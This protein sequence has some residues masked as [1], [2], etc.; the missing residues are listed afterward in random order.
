MR[1]RR[2]C[3]GLNATVPGVPDDRTATPTLADLGEDALLT[4]IFPRLPSTSGALVGP[5]DDAAVLVAPDGRVVAT[6]DLLVEGRDFRRDWST[7]ADVGWKAAAQNLA[8]IAAMGARP[9]ALLVGLVAPAQLEVAWVTGLADGLAQACQGSGVGVVGGDLSSGDLLVVAVTALGDLQGRTPVLR[10]GARA[11][12]V[13]AVAGTLGY[14]AAGLALLQRGRAD[15]APELVAAHRRPTPPYPSGVVAARSAATAMLDV[16]DGL[17]RDVGRIARASG[18]VVDLQGEALAQFAGP[19]MVAAGALGTDP[20]AWVLGG[21][22]EHSLVA[23]FARGT[24]VPRGFTVIG[25]VRAADVTA[26]V[27][28]DG[29]A[30]AVPPGWDHFR[31]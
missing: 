5:G 17:L 12:D 10:S 9:T 8:D 16:S 15:V 21:G 11:G 20:M 24:E 4:L 29:Q 23:T 19:L 22:E 18:M 31:V 28:V 14:C 7:A 2:P 25:A 27:L 6:T 30:A 1:G 3:L 26:A 13:V